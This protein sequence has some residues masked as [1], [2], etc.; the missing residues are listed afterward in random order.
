MDGNETKK[1]ARRRGRRILALMLLVLLAG[2]LVYCAAAYYR[3]DD[4]AQAALVPDGSVTVAQTGYGY[5]FDG[6]GNAAALIFYPGA[7]VEETA[8]APL[9]RQLA[10][11]GVDVCLLK[12]PLHMAVLSM[13]RA[14]SVL[15][16]H[17]YARW[18][19]GGHSLGGAVAA[20]CAAKHPEDFAGVVLLAAYPT[21]QLDESLTELSLYGSE[22]GVLNRARL[23]EGRQYA[24]AESSELVIVGGNHAQF[25]SYG[26]Q[27]GDGEA[28]ISPEE[29][30]TQAADFIAAEI[31]KAA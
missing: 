13:D 26:L 4:T 16:E 12:V 2:G 17:D 22:D 31:D 10:E 15:G 24:P 27:R 21:K 19:V 3:A 7:M 5:Y 6:P 8:Y 30:W 9:L 11:R 18:Y 20:I 14:E 1:Q 28:A 23:E 29:Q 25:G